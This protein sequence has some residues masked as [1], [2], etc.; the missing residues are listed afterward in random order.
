M[1]VAGTGLLLAPWG[2]VADE[3]LRARPERRAPYG[4]IRRKRPAGVARPK[5]VRGRR[6]RRRPDAAAQKGRGTF[7]PARP[8]AAARR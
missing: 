5:G 6:G 7:D 1:H 2:S 4:V 3:T 8:R